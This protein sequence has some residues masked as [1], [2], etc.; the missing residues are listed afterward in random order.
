MRHSLNLEVTYSL[1]LS[2]THPAEARMPA[3]VIVGVRV[4]EGLASL[5]DDFAR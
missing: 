3:W 4:T 2:T 1:D 5:P